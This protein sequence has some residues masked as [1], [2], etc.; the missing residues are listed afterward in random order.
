MRPFLILAALAGL[1]CMGA[2]ASAKS[3]APSNTAAG[4]IAPKP[5]LKLIDAQKQRV[6]QAIDGKDTL[7]KVPEGFTPTVGATAP[8]QKKLHEQPLPR[9]LLYGIPGRRSPS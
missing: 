1:V 9:P 3:P 8:T 7:E 5:P 2:P 4:T 6:V